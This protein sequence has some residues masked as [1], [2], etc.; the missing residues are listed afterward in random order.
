MG[1]DNT[2]MAKLCVSTQEPETTLFKEHPA[3]NTCKSVSFYY[4]LAAYTRH[5]N[6]IEL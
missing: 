6:F 1:P 2:P 4:S 5:M 3:I